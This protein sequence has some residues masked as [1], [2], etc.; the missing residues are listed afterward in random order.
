[1]TETFGSLCRGHVDFDKVGFDL[2]PLIGGWL[3]EEQLNSLYSRSKKI[4]K[5]VDGTGFDIF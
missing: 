5:I 1:M 3:P 4:A 2:P